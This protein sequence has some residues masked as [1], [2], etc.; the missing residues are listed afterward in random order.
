MEKVI[1]AIQVTFD[2]IGT[3]FTNLVTDKD[4]LLWFISSCVLLAAGIYI[5]REVVRIT[6]RY[7]EQH[8]GK[9]SLVRETSRTTGLVGFFKSLFSTKYGE[10][11]LSDV[12]LNP[13]LK[14]RIIEVARST[15]NSQKHAAPYRHLLLYGP[16]GTGKTM[17]AKR[18]AR[19]SGLDYAIMSGGD[20]GPLGSDAVTELHAIFRWA[21]SS[22]RGVLLFIDEAEAFLGCRARRDMSEAMRNAL[23]AL[24]YQTGEQSQKFMMVIATNRPEDLDNAVTDRIDETLHFK[25]PGEKERLGMLKMY[26]KR[27]I[28]EAHL[29][30]NEFGR[31]KTQKWRTAV[32][33][34]FV[35]KM[36]A[37]DANQITD[38]HL[39]QACAR[40][41][42]MS[43][44]EISKLLMYLQSVVYGQDERVV[45]VKLLNRVVDDKVK[46]H[47]RKVQLKSE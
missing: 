15:K 17:V 21:K 12:V 13:D 46:E 30:H 2:N 37:I 1:R 24:L 28:L 20:V 26:Y 23:N 29:P 22:P 47:E 35:K 7:V 25:L 34:P 27:Y 45:T 44:R 10:E 40:T 32:V 16:P 6:G 38:K 41:A 5:A 9:P 33:S 31:R 19:C 43:G 14:V 36:E 4:K 18:L 42:G 11:E 39:S 8:L 3:G